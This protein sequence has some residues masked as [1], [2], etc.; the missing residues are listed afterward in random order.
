MRKASNPKKKTPPERSA[1]VPTWLVYVAIAVVYTIIYFVTEPEASYENNVAFQ[2][3]IAVGVGVV[4][5]RAVV[6]LA[7]DRNLG[8]VFKVICAAGALVYTLGD[9]VLVFGKLCRRFDHFAEF[10]VLLYVI[11]VVLKDK[12][13]EPTPERQAKH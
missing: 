10:L 11:S 13:P 9:T 1:R 8:Q 2:Q 7:D 6:A 3:W 5:I 4:L 12:Q